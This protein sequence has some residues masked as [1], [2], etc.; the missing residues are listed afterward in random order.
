[1]CEPLPTKHAMQ[2]LVVILGGRIGDLERI[3]LPLD[4]CRRIAHFCRP[5][6]WLRCDRCDVSLLSI[7]S[8]TPFVARLPT[9][10]KCESPNWI[11][12]D[13]G[14][15]L[16]CSGDECESSLHPEM[17]LSDSTE[18]MVVPTKTPSTVVVITREGRRMRYP[19]HF[20]EMR[21]DRWYKATHDQSLC[22][23]CLLGRRRQRRCFQT[24]KAKV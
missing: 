2:S 23:S 12:T 14:N 9:R 20:V 24:W 11:L 8:V 4:V 1:M 5:V 18:G 10:W 6:P 19:N 13:R 21:Q 15:L 3:R 16:Q 17:I 7:W 22:R